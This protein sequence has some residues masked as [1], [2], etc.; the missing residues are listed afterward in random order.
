M[1]R[2]LNLLTEA[3]IGFLGT[4]EELF[5]QMT[6]DEVS[7]DPETFKS[8][9]LYVMHNFEFQGR[10]FKPALWLLHC[11]GVFAELFETLGYQRITWFEVNRILRIF[12]INSHHFER[13]LE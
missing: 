4:A 2:H 3:Q 13:M 5:L 7:M 11:M 9:Y 1:R 8:Y 6:V 10:R 12:V